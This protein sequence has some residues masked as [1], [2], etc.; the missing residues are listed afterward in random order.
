MLGE[1]L[2]VTD[3]KSIN[4]IKEECPDIRA[5]SKS[6]SFAMAYGSG[7]GKIQQLLKCTKEEA[8]A[9]FDGYHT[10]YRDTSVYAEKTI[11]QAKHDGFTTGAFKLKLRTPRVRSIDSQQVGKEGRSLV[12]MTIQSYGLLMNRAGD[13]TQK[14]IEKEGKVEDVILVNQIHDALYGLCRDDAETMQW[15]NNTVV[16]AMTEDFKE[17]QE[18][19][20]ESNVD[21][22]LS[23]DKTYECPNN[24][25]IE[26]IK[27]LRKE[28]E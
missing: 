27:N 19:K 1:E 5:K 23:W 9:V 14:A 17:D 16:G 7:A 21:F 28:F 11:N 10:L 26:E 12:N 3:P 8:E 18:I 6:P 13:T 4:R 2:D 15:V 25:S 20:L 24:A 22:G